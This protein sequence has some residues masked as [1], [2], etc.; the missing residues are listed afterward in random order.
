MSISIELKEEL[1]DKY[2]V[3]FSEP[4]QAYMRSGGRWVKNEEHLG[5]VTELITG[6]NI[7]KKSSK[8]YCNYDDHQIP[9]SICI[10]G[11]NLCTTLYRL[12]HING[13]SFMVGSSCITKAGFDDFSN[14]VKCAKRN[15]LCIECK[16]PLILGGKRRN[17][18]KSISPICFECRKIYED[19]KKLERE[20]EIR[21]AVKQEREWR[22]RENERKREEYERIR[23]QQRKQK[24]IKDKENAKIKEERRLLL[25][26][27]G[28]WVKVYF[29]YK[30]WKICKKMKEE[31]DE[32]DSI[33]NGYF[34]IKVED[35]ILPDWLCDF[36][37]T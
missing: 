3:Y 7:Y 31:H 29:Q 33:G 8:Y 6:D 25:E 24:K 15:G 36:K 21:E 11:C 35:G 1:Y 17:S 30:D 26:Q 12:T 32:W 13:I 16:K 18:S 2:C 23:R 14:D 19:R 27:K 20:R 37:K 28:K 10:C 9:G 34:N 5:S 22:E 4:N